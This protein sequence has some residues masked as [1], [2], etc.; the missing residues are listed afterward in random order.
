MIT[1]KT[2]KGRA[3]F[4]RTKSDYGVDLTDIYERYSDAK[5]K[6]MEYCKNKFAMDEFSRHFRII[7]YNTFGFSVA[8]DTIFEIDGKK[9]HG[10]HIETPSNAYEVALI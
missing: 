10:V 8:W 9:V 6:A 5:R 2:A 4:E 1:T 3:L 7:S